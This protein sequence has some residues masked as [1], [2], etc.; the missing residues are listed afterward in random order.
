MRFFLTF[1][2]VFLLAAGC[3]K[4]KLPDTD[5]SCDYEIVA[6]HPHDVSYFTQ[7]LEFFGDT[8]VEGTGQYGYSK[9]VKYNYKNGEV[10]GS[11]SLSSAYFGE[12]ITVLNGKIY[13]LTWKTGKC[14][15]YDFATL[16]KTGEFS[17]A[18]EGW[19]LCNDGEN[20]IMSNGSSS[21]SFRNPS[22][23]S[24]IRTLSVKD[25]NNVSLDELNELEYANGMIYANVW[26]KDFIVSID[27]ETGYIKRK[28]Y[29]ADLRQQAI[30]G[31][32]GAEVL[33]GIAFRNGNFFVTGKYWPKIFEIKLA[34]D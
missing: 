33:N 14:F 29:M 2:F 16:E 31:F 25:S 22:D 23:F 8:L 4:E 12:G 26:W 10:Y 6:I 3:S 21:I 15:V 7:G 1:I 13:Q 32:A 24:I 19:G 30:D 11:A 28:Y 18:G 9:L 5:Y 27:P 34:G 20:L 17:Y